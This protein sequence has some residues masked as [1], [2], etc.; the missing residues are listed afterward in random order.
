MKSSYRFGVRTSWPDGSG[1][2][3]GEVLHA[4][5]V[6]AGGIQALRDFEVQI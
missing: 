4:P 3:A 2:I 6:D 1:R 5:A